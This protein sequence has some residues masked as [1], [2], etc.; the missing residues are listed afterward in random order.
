MLAASAHTKGMAEKVGVDE[1]LAAEAPFSCM[2]VH[3]Q[4]D[5]QHEQ[6]KER[7]QQFSRRIRKKS[8]S[9]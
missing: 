2:W 7:Q 5:E 4:W 9:N 8:S 3:P 1:L 6:Q